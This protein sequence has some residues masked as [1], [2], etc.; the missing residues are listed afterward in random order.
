METDELAPAPV[1]VRNTVWMPV[2]VP[3]RVVVAQRQ[4]CQPLELL[5]ATLPPGHEI[6]QP[7]VWS[8]R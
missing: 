2:T 4:V 3:D 5:I 6:V 1:K 7:P 8:R